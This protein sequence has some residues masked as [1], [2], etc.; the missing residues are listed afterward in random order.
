MLMLIFVMQ[1][2]ICDSCRYRCIFYRNCLWFFENHAWFLFV[3]QTKTLGTASNARNDKEKTNQIYPQVKEYLAF[4]W[5]FLSLHQ[6]K[7]EIREF[8]L[9][10]DFKRLPQRYVFAWNYKNIA[11]WSDKIN[12]L[13]EIWKRKKWKA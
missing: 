9:L 7:K 11:L 2:H 5:G 3:G 12:I 8:K 6:L 1:I 4:M 10:H 13:T